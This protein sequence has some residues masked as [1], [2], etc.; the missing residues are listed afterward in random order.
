MDWWKLWVDREGT[1]SENDQID[2]VGILVT[3]HCYEE[4]AC[5]RQFL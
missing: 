5:P 1:G 3:V 4:T 2:F